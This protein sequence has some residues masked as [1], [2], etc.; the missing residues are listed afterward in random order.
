[1]TRGYV[2]EY[3][4]TGFFFFLT[5][6]TRNNDL[7]WFVFFF[8]CGDFYVLNLTGRPSLNHNPKTTHH[9]HAKS[10]LDIAFFCPP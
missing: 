5:N 6:V 8:I 2:S 9:P 3:D 1:M 10:Y 7:F 4:F